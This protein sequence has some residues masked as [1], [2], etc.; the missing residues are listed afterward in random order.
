[1]ASMKYFYELT[2]SS[3]PHAHSR[4]TT[5]NV[6]RDVLIALAPALIASVYFF[7]YQALLVTVVSAAACVVFEWAYRKIL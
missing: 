2:V 1:M 7:G 3:S 5:Q 6:M 4:F